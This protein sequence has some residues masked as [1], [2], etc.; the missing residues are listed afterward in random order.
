MMSGGHF[1]HGQYR[2]H[3]IAS[4]IERLIELNDSTEKD[5]F[6]YDKGN[7]YPPEIIA[8][9][10]LAVERIKQAERMATRIDYL[11]SGD[12]GEESFLRRWAEEG[13][14]DA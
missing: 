7:H 13:L 6:G 12:D 3:D 8:R 14:P 10:K 5:H 1:N 9:F 2:L 11:V 4:E